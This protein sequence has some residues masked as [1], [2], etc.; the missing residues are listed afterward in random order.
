MQERVARQLGRPSGRFGRLIAWALNH[1]NRSANAAG[2]ERLDVRP[3]DRVLDLGFGGGGALAVLA[4]GPAGSLTGVD[5]SPEMVSAAARRFR[6]RVQVLEASVEA[7][8]FPDDSFDRILSTHT[9]YFWPDPRAGA[10]ELRRVLA[11]GGR[12]VLVLGSRESMARRRVHRTGFTLYSA[13][14][15]A[16]LLRSSG[17]ERVRVDADGPLFAVADA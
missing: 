15:I 10:R 7:L 4:E 5:P 11:P 16:D 3:G 2:L 14:E 13:D 6:G 12:L 8:P 9:V 17:F 1:A